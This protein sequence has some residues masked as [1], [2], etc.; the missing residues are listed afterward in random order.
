[1]NTRMHRRSSGPLL[2]TLSFGLIAI[3]GGCSTSS[4]GSS[5]TGSGGSGPGPGS[6]GSNSTGPG[7]QPGAGGTSSTGLGGSSNSGVG[8]SVV[9]SGGSGDVGPGG[10]S[11]EA[12]SDG[13]GL[14]GSPGTGGSSPIGGGGSAGTSAGL[15][16]VASWPNGA[17]FTGVRDQ[18]TPTLTQ[19]LKVHN[20]GTASVTITALTL[21]GAGK[22]AFQINGAPQLPMAL[23][24]G[25]DLP[26]T[27]Q[28]L[29]ASNAVGP[30]PAQNSGAAAGIATLTATAGSVSAQTNLYSLVLTVPTH[31]PTLGQIL[32]ELGYKL[33][34][35]P[36]GTDC[37][38]ISPSDASK[39]ST[40]AMPPDAIASSLF[41]KAG[42]GN[43]TMVPVARFSPEGPMPFG[44]YPKGSPTTR[45]MAGTMAT[46]PGN[47][48]TS[49]GA[50]EVLSPTTGAQAFDPG[51][52]VFGLWVYSDQMSQ[53]YSTGGTA[54]NGDY[55]Y[56]EDAP[57]S[58]A[59]THRTQVFPL[60]DAT[61]ALVPNSF[62]IAVE[63][64][65]N[66]DYQDYVFVLG[67]AKASP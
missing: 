47:A 34:V 55:D 40:I 41:V 66:G 12:G 43:V 36:E 37:N 11:G 5:P 45:N 59:G 28:A 64:A 6:A 24:A 57:N 22:A 38:L 31:E 2:V 14:G 1:M 48:Q 35:G 10:T 13:T 52:A 19:T 42:A 33:N 44:W 8:G 23:A 25:A 30:A 27:V 65:G 50:R 54:S 49:N 20:G 39:L 15:A 21:G 58:P 9:S 4:G 7:G 56:S 18:A 29:T 32:T 3:A 51:T 67:N 17:I 46:D 60:K 62:L 26:V 61:G 16:I 53:K 63:E